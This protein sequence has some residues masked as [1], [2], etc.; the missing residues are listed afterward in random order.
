MSGRGRADGE[1]RRPNWPL[2]GIVAGALAT[3]VI[4]VVIFTSSGSS[5]SGSGILTVDELGDVDATAAARTATLERRSN[6]CLELEFPDGSTAWPVWPTGTTRDGED[7]VAGSSRFAAGDTVTGD[8]ATVKKSAVDALSGDSG[9]A[10]L[11]E[12]CA[13]DDGTIA[14]VSSLR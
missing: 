7:V 3:A 5:I 14:I 11:A 1:A 6:G 8:I 2:I 10:S 9:P 4:I 12:F 13:G